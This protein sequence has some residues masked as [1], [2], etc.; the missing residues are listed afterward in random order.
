METYKPTQSEL[1][2]FIRDKNGYTDYSK[3]QY[4]KPT[5]GQLMYVE[6]TIKQ[7][8]PNGYNKPFALLQAMK[9]KMIKAGYKKQCLIIK[10]L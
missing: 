3:K 5:H 7:V 4:N 6:G 1:Q 9:A 2:A 10:N 8:V